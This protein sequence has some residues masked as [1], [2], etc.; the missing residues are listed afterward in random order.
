M[1]FQGDVAGIGLGEVL[2][3]LARGGKDGVL[4]LY[5][6]GMAAA[7]GIQRGLLYPLES[8]E[9]D[10]DLW[11]LRVETSWAD[12]PDPRLDHG[13]RADIAR[14]ERIEVLFAM[15][16]A[17]SLHFR[18]EPGP[19]PLPR[20]AR[21]RRSQPLPTDGRS[22]DNPWG[23]G[24]AV[25]YLLLEHARLSDECAG[26]FTPER[27]DVP[28][29]MDAG[30]QPQEL[31]A[32]LAQCDGM[33]TVGEIADR[34]GWPLRQCRGAINELLGRGA[35]RL[36]PPRELLALAQRE[37]AAARPARAALR[38]EGWL[39]R[40]EPGPPGPGDAELLLGEWE[41]GRLGKALAWMNPR[42]ARQ[43]V[44]RLDA[45][46]PVRAHWLDRWQELAA[47]QKE[48]P[49][50]RLRAAFVRAALE[51]EQEGSEEVTGGGDPQ[52]VSDLLRLAR[53]LLEGGS[54]WR[55]RLVLRLAAQ[56]PPSAGP[57][58]VE[59]GS[60]LIEVGLEE[61]GSAL[62]LSV[63]R[64]LMADEEHER[65]IS[66]LHALLKLA[67]NC[68][69]AQGLLLAARAQIHRHIRRR[70]QT[71]V[72]LALLL[73]VSVVG[74]VQVKGQRDRERRLAEVTDLL[75][76][77]LEAIDLL[78]HY[79]TDDPSA[80]I[81][82]LR[83]ALQQ[84]LRDDES[85]ARDRWLERF[86]DAREEIESGDP[87]AG[88]RLALALRQPP[89]L[90][91]E[92]NRVWPSFGELHGTLAMR[93]EQ[94]AAR[95]APGLDITAEA[96]HAEQRLIQL[97]EELN[98]ELAAVP[99]GR[100]VEALAF[101]MQALERSLVGRSEER[102]VALQ[103]RLEKELEQRQDWML[104]TARAHGA[105]G[106][107][108]LALRAYDELLAL[109]GSEELEPLIRPEVERT[110]GQADALG[111]A[112]TLAAAGSHGE[113]KAELIAASLD[114]SAHLLPWRVDSV[115]SGAT[116]RMGD[117]S[118]RRTP[119]V[120]QSSFGRSVELRFE[121]EGSETRTLVIDRPADLSVPMHR[122][123]ERHWKSGAV[124]HAA[125]VSVGEDH[126]LAD[127]AGRLIRSTPDGEVVWSLKLDTLGG[128]ARTPQFLPGRPGVLLV[129]SEDGQSW[130]VHAG[131]GRIEGSF[132]VGSPPVEG[133]VG[134]RG[135]IGALFA[136]GTVAIWESS[137]EPRLQPGSR[138]LAQG[139]A[140]HGTAE[141]DRD[142]KVAVLRSLGARQPE[143]ESPFTSWR[144]EVR[145]D[146]Y[147]VRRTGSSEGFT[148]R[149]EGNWQFVAWE[150][151]HALLPGGRLW[152][153]DGE[154]LRSFLPQRRT[155]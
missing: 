65:A 49:V 9:E 104:A 28:R 25:E 7:I 84:R 17:D 120:M 94:D 14:A 73:V 125:P 36:A 54:P 154:G 82:A 75:G 67:P 44:R 62:L 81:Q 144:V 74:V 23:P 115:P 124:V 129:I 93:M 39:A 148:V 153:S 92:P 59:L 90:T 29:P 19:L 78:N 4:T 151:P 97:V 37:L 110:R 150:A 91:T 21:V 137:A 50:A 53:Q 35:L 145:P 13:R 130:L 52:V 3:S 69:E 76:R 41:A 111:R 107:V 117:G 61:D 6:D 108:D 42:L 80:R 139:A 85:Q 77:P 113:A 64:D 143:L 83:S 112:Q 132:D 10:P 88:L 46:D 30:S 122:L 103:R 72:G 118:V 109:E 102:R 141:Y 27:F 95:I 20:S 33:S 1:S 2:Q 131:E 63:A 45:V 155:R 134:V 5:G 99:A 8:P 105:Q 66:V 11:R 98:G 38:L 18:F 96:L 89:S 68:R 142:P 140:R 34:L 133:P 136:S 16:E 149:R 70:Y 57:Q 135:G 100:G 123:P 101:R 24:M 55:A 22:K 119:F 114:P 40:S 58:R 79:F 147:L 138:E 56:N 26:G 116:V 126:V 146:H 32:F 71:L 152:I 121:L 60:R 87:L 51:V 47:L 31:H 43:L 48:A 127:R 12:F 86:E 15:L 106:Q 128:V